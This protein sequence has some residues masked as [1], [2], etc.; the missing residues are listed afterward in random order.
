MQLVKTLIII[1]IMKDVLFSHTCR[2][3]FQYLADGHNRQT[4]CHQRDTF[5]DFQVHLLLLL[6][7]LLLPLLLK[8]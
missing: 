3:Y 8:R 5:L 2:A 4:Y 1:Y 6:L 7:L